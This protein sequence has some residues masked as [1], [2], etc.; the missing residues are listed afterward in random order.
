MLIQATNLS[1]IYPRGASKVQALAGVSLN[2]QRGEFVAITGRSGSGKS[3]LMHLLGCLD[4]PSTGSYLLDGIDVASLGDRALSALRATRIGFVFQTF[5]LL[6][7]S[8]V[9][10]NVALPFLYR[11]AASREVRLACEAALDRVG[12]QHRLDHRPAELSGGEMQR[13]AIARALAA[14][15]DLI[16]A[17]EPT[18]NLDQ[19]TGRD[20]LDLFQSLGEDGATILLVT[21]D[22]GVAARAGRELR[23]S[24]GSFDTTLG[25]QP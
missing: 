11:S 13:V 14:T 12:L 20:I 21:H 25:D 19:A 9:V 17:D 7:E 15:P 2:V 18:G 1:K 6:P 24:D 4:R 10:E 3:T 22:A 8:S 5:H 16:L 23:M